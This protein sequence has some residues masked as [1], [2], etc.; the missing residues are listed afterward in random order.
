MIFSCGLVVSEV[1]RVSAANKWDFWYKPTRE[2]FSVIKFLPKE[3]VFSSKQP[4]LACGKS[5]SFQFSFST[6]KNVLIKPIEWVNFG[7]FLFEFWFTSPSR[8]FISW[9]TDVSAA[10]WRYQIQAKNYRIFSR[11][12]LWLFSGPKIFLQHRSL[13]DKW[14]TLLKASNISLSHYLADCNNLWNI[15]LTIFLLFLRR[16]LSFL[17]L[18]QTEIT[19]IL[20]SS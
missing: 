18:S 15:A 3:E 13:H 8:K 7:F 16:M 5:S 11:A 19:S 9:K 4:K 2:K 1:D 6:A 14:K 12:L 20:V 17:Q 10:E